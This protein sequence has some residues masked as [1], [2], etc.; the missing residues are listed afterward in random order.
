MAS[1]VLKSISKDEIERARLMSEYKYELDLQSKLVTAKREGKKEGIQEGMQKGIE[2]GRE[3]GREEGKKEV[4]NYVLELI[5]QGL[6]YEEIKKK[7][8]EN[9]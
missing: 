1:E 9:K 5:A 7:L 3:E 4:Q 6:T 2:K 8:E